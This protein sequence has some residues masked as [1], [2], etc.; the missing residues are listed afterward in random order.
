MLCVFAKLV[1]VE[2]V[3]G[4]G[5]LGSP[6][7]CEV[8]IT[9]NVTRAPTLTPRP[10]SP[11]SLIA[12]EYV[13]WN[14]PQGLLGERSPVFMLPHIL[15]IRSPCIGVETGTTVLTMLLV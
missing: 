1:V 5:P 3:F 8:S 10:H 15:T 4:R 11:D 12:V 2:Y 9:K 6:R 13:F 14:P 7:S